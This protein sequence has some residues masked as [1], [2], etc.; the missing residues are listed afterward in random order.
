[1]ERLKHRVTDRATGF[2]VLNLD[3]LVI[4]EVIARISVGCKLARADLGGQIVAD[5]ARLLGA[6][7][8]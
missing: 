6:S 4:C 5:Q 7:V 3:L 8:N 2:S 1:M